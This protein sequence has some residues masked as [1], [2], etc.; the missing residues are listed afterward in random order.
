MPGSGRAWKDGSRRGAEEVAAIGIG[1]DS[2][3]T[4][5]AMSNLLVEPAAWAKQQ[6]AE[7]D[8]GDERRTK[9]LV[10]IAATKRPTD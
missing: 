4:E 10:Q 7:C 6:F 8:L 5:R 9:R 3:E 1:D 2:G